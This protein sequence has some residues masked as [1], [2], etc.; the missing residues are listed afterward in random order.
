MKK[1]WKIVI[2]A[3]VITVIAVVVVVAAVAGKTDKR[4]EALKGIQDFF[5]VSKGSQLNQYLDYCSFE[6]MFYEKDMRLSGEFYSDIASITVKAEAE[7]IIDKSEKM[8]KMTGNAGLGGIP[9][10]EMDIYSD[11]MNLYFVS[12]MFQDKLLK[13]DYTEDLYDVGSSYGINRRNM[14]VLQKGYMELFQMSVSQNKYEKVEELLKKKQLKKDLLQIYDH[15]KVEKQENTDNLAGGYIYRVNFRAEDVKLFLQ[16]LCIEYPEFEDKGYLE[17]VN[18]FVSE[19]KGVEITEIVDETGF[20]NEISVENAESGYQLVLKRSEQEKENKSGFECSFSAALTN[21][22]NGIL[23][24][25]ITFDY[26]DTDKTF[27]LTAREDSAGI[28]AV[29]SGMITI[30]KKDGRIAINTGEIQVGFRNASI[31]MYGN[32]EIVFGD[33]T[34]ELPEGK[35]I[36]VLHGE[37]EE[38][39]EVKSEI[40]QKLKGI[41]GSAFR[42]FLS[43]LT[44]NF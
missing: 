36:D 7:G 39:Q 37:P 31:E 28:S 40:I 17:L 5:E 16:D 9:F 8:V 20:I 32:T 29:V 23:N 15:I 19:Q 35:Q 30:D 12:D 18:K 41:A 38:L 14:T 3:A 1:G 44:L 33:Y 21:N 6:D 10:A 42:Q 25:E 13:L 24:G 26:S 11:D 2:A 34:V 22:G 27:Q 4:R 43:S